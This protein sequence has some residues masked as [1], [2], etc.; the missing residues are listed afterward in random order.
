[1][2]VMEIFLLVILALA[3]VWDAFA[4]VYGTLQV[5]GS[6]P[7]QIAAALLFSGLILGFVLNTRRIFIWRGN[8]FSGLMKFFWFV[9]LCYD[10]LTTWITNRQILGEGEQTTV[11]LLVL[12]GLT[13]LVSGS[14]I[15]LSGLW[16]RRFPRNEPEGEQVTTGYP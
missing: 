3:S 2:A 15:L 6:G 7:F 13:L 14:P 1:M 11:Q 5:L 8:F 16:A 12:A 4:T 10:F 9:A